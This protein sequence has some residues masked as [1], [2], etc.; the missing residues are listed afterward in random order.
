MFGTS[1]AIDINSARQEYQALMAP[2]EQ[3]E[4]VGPFWSEV[5][6]STGQVWT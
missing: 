3:L 2:N 5:V 4:Q 1:Q 6:R